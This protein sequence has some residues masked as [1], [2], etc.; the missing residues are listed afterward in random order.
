MVLNLEY[1][2]ELEGGCRTNEKNLFLTVGCWHGRELT[3]EEG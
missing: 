3:R 2:A 1:A